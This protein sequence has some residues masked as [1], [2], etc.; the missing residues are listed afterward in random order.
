M[1]V[2]KLDNKGIATFS[3]KDESTKKSFV[4]ELDE[5]IRE[6]KVAYFKNNS[7]SCEP[8]I[9]IKNVKDL[10][11]FSQRTILDFIHDQVISTGYLERAIAKHFLI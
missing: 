2:Q 4:D 7:S 3:M 8:E 5:Y 1:L 10:L 9:F 11:S 6:V